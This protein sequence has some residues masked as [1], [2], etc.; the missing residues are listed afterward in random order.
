MVKNARAQQSVAA[1]VSDVDIS[2]DRDIFEQPGF[3]G[4]DLASFACFISHI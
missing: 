3:S 1:L 2:V 4:V